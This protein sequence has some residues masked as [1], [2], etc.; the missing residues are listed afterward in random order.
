MLGSV[1][2][3]K[4]AVEKTSVC[5]HLQ[6]ISFSTVL[7]CQESC[8]LPG[9]P[10]LLNVSPPDSIYVICFCDLFSDPPPLGAASPTA[11]SLSLLNMLLCWVTVLLF[12]SSEKAEASDFCPTQCWAHR[13]TLWFSEINKLCRGVAGAVHV[14]FTSGPCCFSVYRVIHSFTHSG[15]GMHALGK[16]FEAFLCQPCK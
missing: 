8:P 7:C 15:H 16:D 4:D 10:L 14:P 9:F 11:F 2:A 6:L 12:L 5:P 3:S 13:H 1:W